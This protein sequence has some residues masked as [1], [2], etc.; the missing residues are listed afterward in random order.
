MRKAFY[1][2]CLLA[3]F[4]LVSTRAPAEEIKITISATVLNAAD[5]TDGVVSGAPPVQIDRTADG[6]LVSY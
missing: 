5:I 6:I 4:L 3:G 1:I 2:L